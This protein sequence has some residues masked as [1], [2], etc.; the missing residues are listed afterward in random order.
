LTKIP[1]KKVYTMI[2]D[3]GTEDFYVL[4][5]GKTV[6]KSDSARKASKW[7]FDDGAD[8]V[9]WAFNLKHAEK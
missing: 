6:H 5:Q 8:E 2:Y 4:Y 7:A 9:V 1:P 3:V